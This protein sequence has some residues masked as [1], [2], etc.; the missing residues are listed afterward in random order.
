MKILYVFKRF[1]HL[2]PPLTEE[3][4][5]LNSI[6]FLNKPGVDR[7][8]LQHTES[9]AQYVFITLISRSRIEL[10]YLQS[11]KQMRGLK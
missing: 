10:H 5:T 4:V 7:C 8:S 3:K 6:C 9:I 2:T 1:R 11:A